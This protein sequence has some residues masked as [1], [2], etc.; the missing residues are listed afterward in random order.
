MNREYR[1]ISNTIYYSKWRIFGTTFRNFGVKH[2]ERNDIENFNKCEETPD[3]SLTDFIQ[4]KITSN[5]ENEGILDI[6]VEIPYWP[7]E[8]DKMPKTLDLENELDPLIILFR[9]YD[10]CFYGDKRTSEF[11]KDC[12]YHLK[13][14]LEINARFHHIDVRG[15]TKHTYALSEMNK[16]VNKYVI[17]DKVDKN[18]VLS[19]AH[20]FASKFR[21][22]L[23]MIVN[24]TILDLN[25]HLP[26]GT[27]SRLYLSQTSRDYEELD[28]LKTN[29]N[30]LG[31]TRIRR[32]FAKLFKTEL[33]MS[34]AK[35]IIQFFHSLN[36]EFKNNIDTLIEASKKDFLSEEEIEELNDIYS[37]NVGTILCMEMDAY[38]L[39]RFLYNIISNED[40]TSSSIAVSGNYH[41]H[42]YDRFLF[43]IADKYNFFFKSN[44]NGEINCIINKDVN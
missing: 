29:K 43:S 40:K 20:I 36:D 5:L 35:D 38:F 8:F 23:S 34:L 15:R 31:K 28:N 21:Y 19:L 27:L 13:P 4:E 25:S 39:P 3:I 32:Q 14:N 41:A 6:Y 22:I 37:T 1:V 11:S 26:E 10:K 7:H 24:D 44:V 30:N 17:K 42:T 18:L 16:Y 9:N 33:G 12:Q 2:F